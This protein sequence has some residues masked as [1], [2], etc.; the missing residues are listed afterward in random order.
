MWDGV[1]VGIVPYRTECASINFVVG[2]TTSDV[3]F[4]GYIDNLSLPTELHCGGDCGDRADPDAQWQQRPVATGGCLTPL[5]AVCLISTA[6]I[7]R[8]AG[9]NGVDALANSRLLRSLPFAQWQH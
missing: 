1:P 5:L 7:N 2:K 6:L 3:G 8:S 9:L 4:K